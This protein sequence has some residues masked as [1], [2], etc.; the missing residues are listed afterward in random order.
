MAKWSRKKFAFSDHCYST[1]GAGGQVVECGKFSFCYECF[2]GADTVGLLLW[3]W[4]FFYIKCKI[5]EKDWVGRWFNQVFL[6][7]LWKVAGWLLTACHCPFSLW[8]GGYSVF[9]RVL[10]CCPMQRALLVNSWQKQ[11]FRDHTFCLQGVPLYFTM[12]THGLWIR[13]FLPFKVRS[14]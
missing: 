8:E 7:P 3:F 14:T 9:A 1:S 10:I 5:F 2:R 4:F 11:Y 13:L 6:W 12:K